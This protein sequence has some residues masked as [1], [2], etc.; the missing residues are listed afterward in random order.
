[1]ATVS[2]LTSKNIASAQANVQTWGNILYNVKIYGAKG[3][4]VTDDTTAIQ[5]AIDA[6]N[7]A[8]GGI[9]LLSGKEF[10]ISTALTLPSN[11]TLKGLG[12]GYTKLTTS[13]NTFN[14]IE[15]ES[16]ARVVTLEDFSIV[17]NNGIGVS[18]AGI[19]CD[20]V[21]G[22]AEH[23]Y[24]NLN[25]TSFFYGIKVKEL[26]WNNTV[27][28]VRINS[29]TNSV[30]CDATSGQSINNL[31][32]RVYSNEPTVYGLYIASVKCWTFIDCNFG[33]HP[34][35]TSQ[36]V[37]IGTNCFGINFT[38]CNFE[39]A[40]IAAGNGGIS[41]WSSSRVSIESCTFVGNEGFAATAYEIL[42]R[43]TSVVTVSN[44]TQVTPGAN[45]TQIGLQNDATLI[46]VD[47]SM[48]AIS[49]LSGTGAT[50]KA[51]GLSSPRIAVSGRSL[52]LSGVAQEVVVLATSNTGRV[53]K[54]KFIYTE[55]SSAD[56]GV[57]ITLKN[58]AGTITYYS[59]TSEVSKA[60]WYE[61]SPAIVNSLINT[62][63]IVF[64]TVGGKTGTGEILCVIEYQLD[65]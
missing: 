17:S 31:F 52:D 8:G 3:D 7:L 22:G 20:D 36:Y 11:V 16:N 40:I 58:A 59:D 38:G 42:C 62:S 56:A 23:L 65:S 34:T 25:I 4:G 15:I 12:M 9:V 53:T 51:F 48:N 43:E 26:W 19:K 27:E 10:L 29:C 35:L 45:I 46:N 2:E 37:F 1:M 63:P 24:F 50:T 60:K 54:I 32:L 61:L 57:T 44:N 18:N 33:G 55:A 5:A 6:A 39:N 28:N 30:R 13:A 64:S 41:V 49:H 14:A 21:S 47:N